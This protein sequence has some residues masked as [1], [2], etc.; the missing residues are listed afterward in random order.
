MDLKEN[1]EYFI[2]TQTGDEVSKDKEKIHLLKYIK[3]NQL[4]VN[5]LKRNSFVRI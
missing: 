2:D 1:T 4:V 3:E 5:M